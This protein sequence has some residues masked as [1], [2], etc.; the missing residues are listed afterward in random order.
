MAGGGRA[1]RCGGQGAVVVIDFTG[2]SRFG[3]AGEHPVHDTVT[4]TCR[5]PN[6][7]QREGAPAG[8]HAAGAACRR[9]GAPGRARGS[10][11]VVRGRRTRC[12]D[13]RGAGSTSRPSTCTPGHPLEIRQRL[14]RSRP[15]LHACLLNISE[16]L[17]RSK[18]RSAHPAVVTGGPR[19]R[20]DDVPRPSRPMHCAGAASC[21][22]GRS[23]S[24]E[25][26]GGSGPKLAASPPKPPGARP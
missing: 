7:F 8:V 18:A 1:V 6:F 26:F 10:P 23:I 5:H 22:A 4:K 11:G 15:V 16:G 9:R 14:C 19:R 2:V 3:V 24:A 12:Q 17:R 25:I 20:A 13:R 21:A